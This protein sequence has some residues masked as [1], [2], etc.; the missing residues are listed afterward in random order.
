MP[1]LPEVETTRR[2]LAPHLEGRRI[3]SVTVRQPKLR[4][5]VAVEVAALRNQPVLEVGRRAK[6]LLI[7]VPD[8]QVLMHLG[9]SGSL[10]VLPVDAP[11]GK[12]D[13]VDLLLDDGH[14]LRF[15]DPRRFGAVLWTAT[16][17]RHALLDH[18]GPEPLAAS[19]DGEYLYRRSRGRR[20]PVK[21]WLM[22]NQ[23]VVGVG[24]IYAQESL[25]LAGIHPSRPAGRISLARYRRLAEVIR[26]V[27]GRAI[28]VGGT[29]LR[30]FTRVD[31]NPGYFAQS[32]SVYGR[33]GEPCVR[34]GRP[35]S[36]GRHGQRSTSWCAACQT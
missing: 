25:F 5:P 17:G 14:L 4:W 29:T 24:N 22:D 27:L 34:C 28:Q 33:A 12:H 21:Q 10:R 13:H 3:A 19:F 26:E 1:E 16:P 18:L 35:L 11:A 2:G 9:M 6:F 15:N 30:D 7:D 31:G 8:G 36:G 32:L 23:V 20:V